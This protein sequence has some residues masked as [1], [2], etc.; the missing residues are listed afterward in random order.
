M[1]NPVDTLSAE[2]IAILEKS[3][4]G[5]DSSRWYALGTRLKGLLEHPLAHAGATIADQGFCSATN[6]VTGILVARA[7]PRTEFGLFVLGLTMARFLTGV[8]NSLVSIPYTIQYPRCPSEHRPIYLGSS[9]I[10]QFVLCI[11]CALGFLGA[12]QVARHGGAS[13]A[14]T[15]M[16]ALLSLAGGAL[17]MREFVRLLMLAELKFWANLAMSL[18]TNASILAGLAFAY[19]N[20][21]L[22]VHSALLIVALGSGI[23]ALALIALRWR[24]ATFA[25]RA[26][27]CDLKCNWQLGRWLLSRTLAHLGAMSA[28]PFVLAAF[29]GS[30]QAGIY[31]ACFQL[32]SLL[33]PLFMGSNLYLRPKASHLAATNPRRLAKV[34]IWVAAALG[35]PILLLLFGSVFWGNRVMAALY[36]QEYAATQQVLLMCVLAVG[37]SVV[38]GPFAV[39][40]DAMKR[41][42]ITFRG[43]LA[44]CVLSLSIGL[45]AIYLFGPLGAALALCLSQ[46]ATTAFW[47]RSFRQLRFDEG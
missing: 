46:G 39:A 10:Q 17:M 13:A 35:V 18:V 28:F 6:F 41:T 40:I 5:T 24:Q 2:S 7:C 29:H 36:G 14:W 37:I 45:V 11:V 20:A 8:Q 19:F 32:A 34:V 1:H 16:L 23:P 27:L 26:M 31:G 9:L 4:H 47:T 30:G 42:D 3:A 33:N 21:R 25:A 38:G 44:G 15:K 12:S 22:N 43:R